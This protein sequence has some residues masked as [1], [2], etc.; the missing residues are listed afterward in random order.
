MARLRHLNA[1]GETVTVV[2]GLKLGIAVIGEQSMSGALCEFV[3]EFRSKM[4]ASKG[5]GRHGMFSFLYV[6]S[7][8]LF[9]S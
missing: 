5:Q 4:R 3:D 6:N 1:N 8:A 2:D 9:V 7:A